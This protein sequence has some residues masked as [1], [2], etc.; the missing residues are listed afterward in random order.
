MRV[1]DD[2]AAYIGGFPTTDGYALTGLAGYRHKFSIREATFWGGVT[3]VATCIYLREYRMIVK[4]ISQDI[5]TTR[6]IAKKIFWY[7]ILFFTKCPCTPFSIDVVL[8]LFTEMWITSCQ[9]PNLNTSYYND[10]IEQIC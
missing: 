10:D 9:Y 6:C 4:S 3:V 7:I 2:G 5:N 1:H 8:A